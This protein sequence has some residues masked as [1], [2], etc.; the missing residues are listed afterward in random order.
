MKSI[1]ITEHKALNQAERIF[2]NSLLQLLLKL[3]EESKELNVELL[4]RPIDIVKVKEE[5]SDV[6]YVLCQLMDR[7]DTNY[8]DCLN[9]AI[10]K[11]EKREREGRIKLKKEL[12]K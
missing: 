1:D 2:H 3:D 9:H 8:R 7:F 11:I 10:K 4:S 12:D 6:A 5:L